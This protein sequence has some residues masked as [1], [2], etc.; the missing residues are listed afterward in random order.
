[1]GSYDS[2]GSYGYYHVVSETGS[3][4]YGGSSTPMVQ[5]YSSG[6]A[7]AGYYDGGYGDGAFYGSSVFFGSG[8]SGLGW[9]SD[10][11]EVSVGTGD[12]V[13]S[14]QYLYDGANGAGYYS[15]DDVLDAQ[16]TS[17]ERVLM[18]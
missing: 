3:G 11:Q 18:V 9:Y 14:A 15:N 17:I 5:S 1:M 10:A 13:A 6:S 12:Y 8:A 2:F 7:G 16:I 4:D